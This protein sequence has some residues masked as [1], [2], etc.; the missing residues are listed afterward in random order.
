MPAETGPISASNRA[1]KSPRRIVRNS[2]GGNAGYLA[3]AFDE[4]DQPG[5]AAGRSCR[6]RPDN[7]SPLAWFGPLAAASFRTSGP[8]L[9]ASDEDGVSEFMISCDRMRTNLQL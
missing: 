8:I 7:R 6:R 1:A 5:A 9:S 3:I 2:G 4:A